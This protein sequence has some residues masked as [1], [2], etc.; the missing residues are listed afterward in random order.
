MDLPKFD[1]LDPK[2]AEV[3]SRLFQ[4]GPA[5]AAAGAPPEGPAIAEE[6]Q[7]L[8]QTWSDIDAALNRRGC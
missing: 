6:R 1:V 7:K 4:L 5:P 3:D 8:A 2:L